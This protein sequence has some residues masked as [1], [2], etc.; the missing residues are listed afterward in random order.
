[1]LYLLSTIFAVNNESN[2]KIAFF[3]PQFVLQHTWDACHLG[4]NFEYF[5]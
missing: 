4:D 5:I 1:M 3:M 2:Q